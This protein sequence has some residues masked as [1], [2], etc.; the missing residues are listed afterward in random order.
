MKGKKFAAVAVAALLLAAPLGAC[1]DTPEYQTKRASGYF[2]DT[3]ASLVLTADYGDA[4]VSARAD[5]LWSEISELLDGIERSI[6]AGYKGSSVDNF[7]NAAAGERVEI[8]KTCY[9]VFAE[10]QKQ[11][12]FTDGFFN[13]AVYYSVDLYGFAPR[14]DS[15]PRPYD[16]EDAS[17]Q[18]PDGQYVTA[19][20]RLSEAFSRVEIEDED[21]KYYA[22]KPETIVEVYGEE[23]TLKIDLGGI[24]KGYAVDKVDALID[25]YGFAYGYFSFGSSSIAVKQ[26]YTTENNE[27]N[28][29]F[30]DPR[31]ALGT[32]LSAVV[33]DCRIST[34]GDYEQYYEIDGKRYCHI[35]DPY[36]GS[37]IDTGVISAT[38]IGDSATEGDALTTSLCAMGLERAVEF[39]NEN[40]SD[41][42]VAL[43]YEG[44]GGLYVITNAPGQITVVNP[45][46]RAGNT[47]V[48]GKI[49]L[50]NDVA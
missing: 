49:V 44:A 28:L 43:A 20:F 47:V 18:L 32:Y 14:T 50:N 46:Y 19:F 6:S 39:I 22:C 21:G 40:L 24:G 48:G 9:E 27:W 11:Y 29:S 26:S 5:S 4:E 30:T 37:P 23:Y 38:A 34:S 10:A 31:A 16:R 33:S 7:N 17:V 2:M 3:E 36:T 15:E 13:P 12:E 1:S 42:L 25:E 8:D 41:R 45:A 35:I